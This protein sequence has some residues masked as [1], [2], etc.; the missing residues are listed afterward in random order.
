MIGVAVCRAL[1]TNSFGLLPVPYSGDE[2]V[3]AARAAL[4]RLPTLIAFF[5]LIWN[6]GPLL[7]VANGSLFSLKNPKIVY[8][9]CG[10]F[11]RDL[12]S[13]NHSL[14]RSLGHPD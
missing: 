9:F 5:L 8:Y 6:F 11:D 3:T 10:P 2:P 13:S 7:L 4:D 14:E 12:D 1:G